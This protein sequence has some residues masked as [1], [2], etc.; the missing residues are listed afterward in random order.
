M[1]SPRPIPELIVEKRDGG[2]LTDE[3]WRSLIQGYLAGRIA[4]YQM[5][6]LLMAVCIRGL[7]DRET[8][9]LTLAMRDSGEVVRFA[10]PNERYVDKHSTGG[11]GDKVSIALAP[12]VAA[13][14][15]RVPMMS[16]RGLGH[17]GGT[18]DKLEAIPH[19]DVKLPL[20]RFV[21]QVET[22]GCA[23][24]GQTEAIAPADRRLY[25]LRD[26]TG[27]VESVPLITASILSKKLA[28]GAR[29]L[30]LDVK[31]GR[32][33]YMKTKEQ[34]RQL[35]ASLVRVGRE[36]GLKIAGWITAMDAPLGT[37]VGNALETREAI[38]FLH[39]EG[40]PDLAEVVFALGADML[41]L[42]GIA[43]TQDD[44]VERLQKARAQGAA[45]EMFAKVVAAQGGDAR[46]VEDPSRLPT[47]TIRKTV[48]ADR[49]GYVESID[50]FALARACVRLG[51][52]RARK[53]DQIDPRVGVRLLAKVGTAVRPGDGLV[54][55]HA[56]SETTLRRELPRIEGSFRLAD[57]EPTPSP[58][59]IERLGEAPS[60]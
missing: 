40:P 2:T 33:A 15:V 29:G 55:I 45:T 41:R 7:S 51:A 44:A 37:A 31:A 38:A 17:A 8:T 19:F 14:G 9:A 16:G 10:P 5:S 24:V 42:A 47:A 34:A 57:A 48:L 60:T 4:D 54:E 53:E 1:T 21:E 49:P 52:G 13:C 35:A 58:V 22:L 59:L 46:V 26:V 11:V 23:L 28:E 50:A 20:G 3:A 32:G 6:A 27:T 18:L 30:V 12:L 36:A 56:S 43:E 25:A 39:G